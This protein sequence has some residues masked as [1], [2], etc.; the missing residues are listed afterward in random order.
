MHTWGPDITPHA[1]NPNPGGEDLL[2]LFFAHTETSQAKGREFLGRLIQRTEDRDPTSDLLV[3]NAQYNAIAE[4]GIP[5]Y[6][7]LQQLT[8]ITAPTFVM[9]G[10]NDLMVPT[11]ASY[12]LAGLI[13]DARIKIYPDAAHA[14]LFQ[15]PTEVGNDVNVFL[16]K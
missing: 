3:R 10:D 11:K 5:D 1:W 15:Y 14:F 9:Q 12:L 6:S 8:G 16:S 4:W 7:K 13:P 2:Y